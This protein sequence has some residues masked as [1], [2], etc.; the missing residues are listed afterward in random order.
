MITISVSKAKLLKVCVLFLLVLFSVNDLRSQ[1][2]CPTCWVPVTKHRFVT[3]TV[4]SPWIYGYLEYLP[5]AYAANPTKKFPLII[6][7]SGIGSIGGGTFE[8]MCPALVCGALPL[9]IEEG[10][11]PNEVFHNGVP[12]S[13]IVLT[14]Q[15]LGNVNGAS[16][17]LA[18]INYAVANYRV[19]RSRIYLTGLSSGEGMIMNYMSS[20]AANA[21]KVAAVV[22]MG[23]CSGT[24][25]S[26]ASNI[27]TQNIHY[28][29]IQ[30]AQ[31]NVCSASNVVNWA[32]AVNSFS[33]PGNPMGR[34]TLTPTYNPSF[35]HD[36][37]YNAYDKEWRDNNTGQSIYEW[38][39]QFASP[40][41]VPAIIENFN[42]YARNKQVTVEWTSLTESESDHFIIERS[43]NGADFYE[44]GKVNAAGTS[45]SKIN[46]SFIDPLPLRGNNFYRLVLANRDYSKDYFDIKKVTVEDFG[47]RVVLSPIPATKTLQLI[48]NLN[49]TQNITFNIT[50]VNGRTLRTWSANFSSG[51]ANHPIDI[52][53]LAAG[54]YYL[55]IRGTDFT[56]TKKFIKQ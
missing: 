35:P 25:T 6:F 11:V 56:E 42:V 26:G 47:I 15:M 19:D 45:S 33:P 31:D 48:F 2:I 18:M 54:V 13:F 17:I 29:G 23:A 3:N 39:I 8:S 44:I 38:M 20:S 41:L 28:W 9:K 12:Y 1:S 37:W 14:P 34:S 24:N 32:N 10:R 51:N 49:S 30:C 46:Y 7:I 27:G 40:T 36:I 52:N 16:D 50:D 5:P 22:T 55:H 4:V 21:K 53:T 43:A